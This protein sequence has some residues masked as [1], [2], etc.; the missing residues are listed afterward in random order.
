MLDTS[1]SNF[2]IINNRYI[3]SNVFLTPAPNTLGNE[4]RL[5]SVLR[6]WANY[7]ENMSLFKDFPVYKERVAWRLGA[8]AS[9]LFNRHQW[10]DPDTNLSDGSS[11]GAVTGQCN[12][13]RV[14]E[15]YTKI[16]F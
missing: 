11:F 5:D 16:T 9:N 1:N 14:F 13:P 15:L 3:S 8:N 7:N 12:L 2:D 4:G 6:G 10:C